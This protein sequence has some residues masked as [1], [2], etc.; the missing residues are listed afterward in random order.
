MAGW[1]GWELNPV[2]VDSERN[3]H[4]DL[5]VVATPTD[6][7]PRRTSIRRNPPRRT[8]RDLN[9]RLEIVLSQAGLFIPNP[10]PVIDRYHYR[11][12]GNQ[13]S[14]PTEP[15]V[16]SPPTYSGVGY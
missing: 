3:I 10:S 12:K 8:E 9:P 2:A 6:Q 7:R 1:G 11:C 16:L 15:F 5:P 13:R 4:G 14:S